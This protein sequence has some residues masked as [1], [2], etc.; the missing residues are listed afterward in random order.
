MIIAILMI[1]FAPRKYV[2]IPFLLVIFLGAIG[3]QIYI[4]GFHFYVMRILII[5][6]ILRLMIAK[7]I[8][9]ETL[10]VE[11]FDGIDKLFVMWVCFRCAAN[12]LVNHGETGAI[13]YQA[14]F[15]LD[16][17]GG[18]FFLRFLIRD[19]ADIIRVIKV[20]AALTFIFGLTMVDEKFHSQNI[21][22]YLGGVSVVPGAREGSI[23]AG[24][25]F[26]HPILAGVF[27]VAVMPLFWWLWQSGKAKTGG[28]SWFLRFRWE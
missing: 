17:I 25:A 4:N 22:G 11:G 10:L 18:F 21:F 3:Q 15:M 27:G 19:E 5:A 2:S 6:G 28:D 9:K 13:A 20:F 23:R 16:C 8:S 1:F 24:A 12:I 7:L 26:A 14:G